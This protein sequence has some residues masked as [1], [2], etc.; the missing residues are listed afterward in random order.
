[1]SGFHP[2]PDK[3]LPP[4]LE[5][6]Q[7]EARWTRRLTIALFFVTLAILALTCVLVAR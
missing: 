2:G 7:K 1:M 4:L 6:I 5:A 3:R